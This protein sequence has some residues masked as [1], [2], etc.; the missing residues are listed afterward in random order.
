MFY[1][2]LFVEMPFCPLE[3]G[4][5]SGSSVAELKHDESGPQH[6]AGVFRQWELTRDQMIHV[7][8]RHSADTV[9]IFNN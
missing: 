8:L 9:V 5:L 6:T 4:D 1:V 2:S 3:M 7:P